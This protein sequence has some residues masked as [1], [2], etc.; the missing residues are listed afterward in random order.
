MNGELQTWLQLAA[1]L[2]IGLLIGLERERHPEAKAGVRTFALVALFGT[3]CVIASDLLDAAWTVPLGLAAVAAM[4]IA[5]YARGPVEKDP[6]TTTVVAACVCFLLGV[7]AGEGETGIAGALAIG[8]TALLYF[9]PEIEGVSTALERDEQVSVLQ[10][11]VASFIVLPILPDRTFGPYHVLNPRNIWLMVVLVSGIGLA[12]Y[13]ALRFAGE[14]RGAMIAG[15][16]G[17]LVS[18][19]ATTALYARRSTESPALQRLAAVA[20]PLA[21]L[22]PIARVALIAAI[23]AP[24]I[25]PR[26]APVL[27]AALAAGL[28]ATALMLRGLEAGAAPLPKSRNPAELGAAIRFGAFYAV[29]L[30][31]SAW[32]S[33]LAGSRG[34]Y[35]AAA[36][37]GFVDIDAIVLSGLNLFA[38]ERLP[39]GQVVAAIA[40]AY[41]ANLVFKLGVLLW[42]NRGLALRAAA[43]FFAMTAAG[44][45]VLLWP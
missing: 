44:A 12:G 1:S 45:A 10:F 16:L 32:L 3:L 28:A 21:N 42:F 11:L 34:F 6:G 14:R 8:V 30:F 26:L 5:A 4:L 40:I 31:A 39:G 22:V 41:G 24:A 7:L 15:L 17:G 2:A 36:L 13:I 9:K 20:V 18:S 43:P 23:V 27:G 25:L 33:D 37:S 19:T 35:A 29:V 38:R